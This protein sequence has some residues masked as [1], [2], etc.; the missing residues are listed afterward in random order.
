MTKMNVLADCLKT[1]SNA[2]KRGK[3][4]VLIKP[5]SKVVIKFLQVM[6][7]NGKA[8]YSSFFF[9]IGRLFV[10][11]IRLHWRIRSRR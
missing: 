5:S 7:K 9:S 6:Q 3:R 8:T 11:L 4:Q 10:V 2:E 1:L